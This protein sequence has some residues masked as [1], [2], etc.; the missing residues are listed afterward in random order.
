MGQFIVDILPFVVWCIVVF[1]GSQL[2]ANALVWYAN[3]D[4]PK[5]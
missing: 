3:R 5:E 1:G 4:E 2:I